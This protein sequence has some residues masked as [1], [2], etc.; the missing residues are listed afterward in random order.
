VVARPLA[1]G[2]DLGA[3]RETIPLVGRDMVFGR[4]D[5]GLHSRSIRWE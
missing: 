5:D 1:G 4:E 3:G 2:S